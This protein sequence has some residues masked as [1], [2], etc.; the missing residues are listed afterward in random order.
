[1]L[2]AVS[3]SV[4][5]LLAT[6]AAA[7]YGPRR[8]YYGPRDDYPP[9]ERPYREYYPPPDA[10]YR[11]TEQIMCVVDRGL[12]RYRSRPTCELGSWQPMGSDCACPSFQ[13][14]RQRELPG[15][16]VPRR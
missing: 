13:S 12:E 5:I 3:A 9:R 10:S 2:R 4:L 1:M 6:A 11:G 15:R 8:E 7:Q 16:V 14:Q